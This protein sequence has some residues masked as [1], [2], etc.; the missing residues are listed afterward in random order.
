MGTHFLNAETTTE[1]IAISRQTTLPPCKSMA[2]IMVVREL[3]R[4]LL[5]LAC[6]PLIPEQ[7]KRR[8]DFT[9]H[10]VSRRTANVAFHLHGLA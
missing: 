6:Q 4:I 7:V 8:H 2:G 9:P 1:P 10:Q 5:K 3:A